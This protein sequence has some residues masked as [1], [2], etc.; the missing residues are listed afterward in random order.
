MRLLSARILRGLRADKPQTAILNPIPASSAPIVQTGSVFGQVQHS[1]LN[2]FI[3]GVV[4]VP[5][6]KV[7]YFAQ[8]AK[9][10]AG[11]VW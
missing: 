3:H 7:G 6:R 10:R 5:T 11:P 2:S 4:I 1:R 8:S 9:P